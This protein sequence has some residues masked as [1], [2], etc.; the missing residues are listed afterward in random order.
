MNNLSSSDA[1]EPPSAGSEASPL[2]E[3]GQ[4]IIAL[5]RAHLAPLEIMLQDDSHKHAG[6]PGARSGGRHYTLRL[7]S[8]H[9]SGQ[10]RLRRHRLVYDALD[11]LMKR[12]IHALSMSLLAP[13]E[14]SNAS[15]SRASPP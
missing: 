10:S 15:S 14:L 5:L 8:P 9:F 4:Q 1:T 2:D 6:H 13:E 11:T 12:E 7:I 3:T